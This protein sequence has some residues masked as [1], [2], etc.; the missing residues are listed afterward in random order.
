LNNNSTITASELPDLAPGIN[1]DMDEIRDLMLHLLQ[2]R[3][4]HLPIRVIREDNFNG[5]G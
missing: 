3:H 2:N 4:Y 1:S 5:A